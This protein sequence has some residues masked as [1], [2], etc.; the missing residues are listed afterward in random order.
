MAP[1]KV[2]LID[3][4]ADS[5][6]IYSLILQHHGYEVLQASD[7]ETGL[8]LAIESRPDI[9]VSELFL[10]PLQAGEIVSRLQKDNR[11][12]R[13]PLIVL[14]S[15]PSIRDRLAGQEGLRRLTKPCEPSRLLR[16][17]EQ[18]LATAQPIAH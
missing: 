16:E 5:I 18:L 11:T 9:V 7:G 8:R 15:T 14:D 6:T 2:L 4:D 17:I 1:A 13:T 12:A 10:P 3:T